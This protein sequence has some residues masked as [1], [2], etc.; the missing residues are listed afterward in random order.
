MIEQAANSVADVAS[1]GA[2]AIKR[3]R[4]IGGL[5]QRPLF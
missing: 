2:V 5:V 1:L 4:G 3:N